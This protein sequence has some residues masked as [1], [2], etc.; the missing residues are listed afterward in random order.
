MIVGRDSTAPPKRGGLDQ[1]VAE[2]SVHF[3]LAP[4]PLG[5]V[6]VYNAIKTWRG[7]ACLY[8]LHSLGTVLDLDNDLVYKSLREPG[9]LWSTAGLEQFQSESA[10]NCR[11]PSASFL[12]APATV[13]KLAAG[14][15]L[16]QSA[17]TL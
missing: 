5:E 12:M 3:D 8:D 11:S 16:T 17:C 2:V 14:G 10:L 13:L 6:L 4:A 9:T 1:H 7:R 15:H